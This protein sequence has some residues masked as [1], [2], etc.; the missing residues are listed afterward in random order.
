MSDIKKFFPHQSEAYHFR[1]LTKIGSQ[2]AWVDTTRDSVAVP[3][4]GDKIVMKL[5]KLPEGV[6]PK[7]LKPQPQAKPVKKANPPQAQ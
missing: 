5:L 1:F 2:K 4:C 3:T 7:I 6:K